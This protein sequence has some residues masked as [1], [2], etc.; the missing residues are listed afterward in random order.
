MTGGSGTSVT[1]GTGRGGRLGRGPRLTDGSA[2]T[3]GTGTVTE[4]RPL[5][6]GNGAGAGASE[7]AGNGGID[8]IGEEG[9]GGSGR[10]AVALGASEPAAGP[11]A[12]P[13]F[14]AQADAATASN[15]T[16][17]THCL[18]RLHMLRGG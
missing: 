4:G 12:P 8:E 5:S 15:V 10:A 16:P 17:T 11:S 18:I 3:D 9:S 13:T 7:S 2:L 6:A 14:G 1:D